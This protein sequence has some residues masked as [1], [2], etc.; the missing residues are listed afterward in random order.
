MATPLPAGLAPDFRL[1][2]DATPIPLLVLTPDFTMVAA[3][4]ARL[5]ATMTTREQIL[6][7]NVFDVFPDNPEDATATGATN[8]RASLDRV[9]RTRETDAMPIQKYDIPKRG[10]AGSGFEV[11]YWKP[12]NAPVLD[13][14]GEVIYIIHC[15]EDVTEQVLKQQ[16]AEAGEA[17]FRQIADAIPQMVWSARPSGYHDYY[18]RRHYEFAGVPASATIGDN[19]GAILHPDDLP[20]TERA[21]KH[22]LRT[23][24]PY[25]IEY[26]LRHRS[27]NY[28]WMLARALPIRNEAGD[29]ERWMG[30]CTDIDDQKTLQVALQDAQA[31]L[32]G[33][34][35][36]AEVGTWTWDIQADRV[37]ADR[38]FARMFQVSDADADG[39]PS[40][41]YLA[42]IHPDDRPAV[43]ACTAE[44]LATGKPFEYQYRL[45]Y[46]D[47]GIRHLQARGRIEVDRDGKPARMLGVAL[48]ISEA[49]KAQS[50]LRESENQFRTLA[51][52][53]PQLAWMAHGDGA[54]FWFNNRWFEYTGTTLADM[55]GW[56]WEKVHHPDFADAVKAKYYEQ[57]VRQQVAWEDL[58]PLR[59]AD[60]EYRWFL[61]R[62][63]PI[64]DRN[65]KIVRWFGTNTDITLQREAE[66]A[67][68][69]ANRR[70][71]EF[72][73]LVAHELRNPL[74]PI[75]TAAQL[76]GKAGTDP[77]TVR[78][79]SG[80]IARQVRH[81]TELVDDLLDV[82]RV[83]RGLVSIDRAVLDIRDAID[84]AI[85]QSR[86][87]IDAR[88]HRL[89][90]RLV[91]EHVLVL[92]DR[93]RLVQALANLLSNA[94]KYTP[95]GGR[96][97]LELEVVASNV[98][99]H[100]TDDGVGM[101]AHFL[102]HVFD[103]FS[104]A[105][106]TPDR[107]Q[108]GLG[109]G[110]A[111]VRSIATQHGGNVTARSDGPGKGS[112]FT[113]SL[114]LLDRRDDA[115]DGSLAIAPESHPLHILIADDNADAATS[116]AALLQTEGHTV[117]IRHDA[118]GALD[119]ARTSHPDA[120]I[121]DIGLPD[122]DGYELSRRLHGLPE[123]GHAAYI[124]LTG[125]GQAH[126]RVL[127]KAAGFDHYFVKPIDMSALHRALAAA[128]PAAL[129]H[130]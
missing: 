50:A 55:Q 84:G 105:E 71:D 22:S 38:N 88:H 68:E 99:V 26:R 65:G 126:D 6:G 91:P 37:H 127:A 19:W 32:E 29:I 98:H 56:G 24:E 5:S 121:L 2:F 115:R 39:G 36:A 9:L 73:A 14:A 3:N 63:V 85:E 18:N 103:L 34:L 35:A 117:T 8:L 102:P 76:L 70:K 41:A 33:T 114:P 72:L 58:F 130:G 47:G 54:I 93:T 101:D 96:I 129:P 108:G 45:R 27:G 69:Q 118:H 15:V 95:M 59:G 1:L 11:R 124:A 116:L 78:K 82:S 113:L 51:E 94:A 20:R 83:T 74:A 104:Q 120:L 62:A 44:S 125:Y 46:P 112:T 128:A 10:P 60:G 77:D 100:V 53:I 110:L 97:R 109:L 17:R 52:N 25:E 40:A 16:A 57:I 31:R 106:Q 81:M 89:S 42:M 43:D 123:T 86:P 67:L 92:G 80:I 12:V 21:W 119:A 79:Y 48:D 66:I 64:R 90:V 111:L 23:G 30:T 4:E 61:S 75:G 7:R 122:M 49:K 13:A 107:S 87:L 28:H